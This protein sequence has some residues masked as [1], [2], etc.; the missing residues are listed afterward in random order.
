MSH[1]NLKEIWIKGDILY[2]DFYSYKS[3]KIEP[4]GLNKRTVDFF[5]RVGLP[6]DASPFLSFVEEFS[7]VTDIYSFLDNSFKRLIHIGS[8]GGGNPIVINI[9]KNDQIEV[10]DHENNFAPL[11]INSTIEDFFYFLLYYRDFVTTVNQKNEFAF[12]DSDYS[13][14]DVLNLKNILEAKNSYD[15]NIGFWKHE[16]NRLLQKPT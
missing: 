15:A 10:L 12:L 6:S 11:F 1:E 13:E 2:G 14:S 3:E 9:D 16:I 5:V 7:F 4:L 8:D